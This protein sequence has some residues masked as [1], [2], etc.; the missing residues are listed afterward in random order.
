MAGVK[1]HL[2]GRDETGSVNEPDDVYAE[3]DESE[4]ERDFKR[5]LEP[6]TQNDIEFECEDCGVE[7]DQVERYT[8]SHPYP[9]EDEHFYLCEKCY[10]KRIQTTDA[11]PDQASPPVEPA[12]KH[13]IET[14]LQSA[15]LMIRVLKTL[16]PNRRIAELERLLAER[17]QV[18]P[19]ME[20]ALEAYVGVL[21]KALDDAKAEDAD[22]KPVE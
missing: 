19:G 17:A 15:A 14:L 12:S 8:F 2:L 1:A 18:A 5:F 6:W 10:E 9:Q 7:S 3:N 13:E 21:Q 22:S 16:P 11:E 4:F 20:P